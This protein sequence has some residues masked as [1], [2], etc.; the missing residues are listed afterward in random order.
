MS[1]IHWAFKIGQ[2][3]LNLPPDRVKTFVFRNRK[4]QI[5][6]AII[7]YKM[8]FVLLF[9]TE[10]F[11]LFSF[12]ITAETMTFKAKL[13]TILG[14]HQISQNQSSIY[15]PWKFN[16]K[17]FFHQRFFHKNIFRTAKEF[18]EISLWHVKE[19]DFLN[20]FMGLIQCDP[21]LIHRSVRKQTKSEKFFDLESHGI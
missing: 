3:M 4:W 17:L 6:N 19:C 5:T 20:A 15:I 21:A 18:F 14:H 2:L 8:L 16:Y 7:K 10:Y 12:E 9:S 11:C 13:R 1:R